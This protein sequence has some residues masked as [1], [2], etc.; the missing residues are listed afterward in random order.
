MSLL[1]VENLTVTRA[2][3]AVLL[4]N[5][6]FELAP[7]AA[8]GLLGESGSG[9]TTLGLALLGLLPTGL[10]RVAGRLRFD[11]FEV[12]TM[13]EAQLRQ[14]RGRR[15]AMVFQDPQASFIPVRRIGA[16]AH[17][18][19]AAHQR[20]SRSAARALILTRLAEV[21][22]PDPE[23]VYDAYPHALSGGMRQRVLIA[24]ALLHDPVLLIADE[25]T[26]ALDAGLRADILALLARLR[27]Q[28]GLALLLISHDYAAVDALCEERLLLRRGQVV[29]QS[30]AGAWH[31]DYAQALMRCV[32][33]LPDQRARLPTI[34]QAAPTA[35]APRPPLGAELLSVRALGVQFAAP[36][37]FQPAPAPTLGSVDLELRAGEVLG[38]VG[39]SG[40]GKTT[41]GRAIAGLQSVSSGQLIWH[42]AAATRTARAQRVQ[43]VFQNPYASLNP[44]LA[45]GAA[46]EQ[47]L[48]LH[49][50]ELTRADRSDEGVR[51]LRA[52]G[53]K[54]EHRARRPAQFSGGERQRIAIARA[55]SVQPKVLICDECT[56][57]L[58]V[59]VQAQLLN[60]LK[61]LQAQTAMSLLFIS[62]CLAVVSFLSD[63]LLV[64]DAGTVVETG[65]TS[66]V[67]GSP[68]HPVTQRL[69]ASAR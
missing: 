13:P 51:L 22:L 48:A 18:I 46:I 42:D 17:S 57:A 9:K 21:G 45:V 40:C 35:L 47:A 4:D 10:Q 58:D 14:L 26:T 30:R 39:G 8:L 69:L 31:S 25:P 19:L 1:C 65:A 34:D 15:I 3:G 52:V 37:W 50:P 44:E 33:M 11:S 5:V 23:W 61:D 16:Q 54:A 43:M 41:L 6:S 27:Q 60:L 24:F 29:E 59:S 28:R 67:L 2:D 55:L 7:G 62:H 56:S 38:I 32:P 66:Q 64:L 68:Q 53:L 49:R 36:R 12:S 20:L 63:R